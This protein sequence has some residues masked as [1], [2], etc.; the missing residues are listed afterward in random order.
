MPLHP[1]PS[2]AP[3]AWLALLGL[4]PACGA[5]APRAP[6]AGL[7]VVLIVIDTLAAEHVGSY[8]GD[9]R[10]T[11]RLDELASRSVRFRH[12][13]APAPWTQPSV[14]SL[15]TSRMPSAHGVLRLRDS[16]PETATTLAESLRERGFATAAVVSHDL[17][18]ARHG[19]LQG[20]EHRDESAIGG[21]RESTSERATDAALAWLE[22]R[23]QD[24]PF[25]L[26]A[27]YFDPHYPYLDHADFDFTH[28]FE[29]RLTPG[30]GIW[31]LLDQRASLSPHDIAYLVALYREEIAAT[32]RAIGR[33]LDGL[34]ARGLSDKTLVIVTAD[35][36]EEFM[37]HGWIGHT[38]TL[39][40]E[41]LAV[42]LVV[43]LPG[44][45]GARTVDTPVS[46]LDLA[47]T[48]LEA[49]GASPLEGSS[50][51][52]LMP[53]LLGRPATDDA[54]RELNQRRLWAEV[55]FVSGKEEKA[56]LLEKTA[57][58]TALLAHPFKLVHDLLGDRWELY[59]RD[60]D[61]HEL[62]DLAAAQPERLAALRAELASW[63][64]ARTAD[65]DGGPAP[66]VAPSS[67]EIERLRALG[68]IE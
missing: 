4:L 21:P 25:F 27:H 36:G 9:P 23:P 59:D 64:A 34:A 2:R 47:P 51:R 10:T 54:V 60:T 28:G 17:I 16:L 12:A 3:Y 58:K 18:G 19:F 6:A 65:A 22:R 5:P 53:L 48:V 62:H 20:F 8:G 37:R 50:G 14:A 38:R 49:A 15:F 7:N 46:L 56:H 67:E 30:L 52:S 63:E 55:S 41:L 61:P 31:T 68:Y 24:R 39:Y 44:R 29:T 45:F 43:S 11:P 66:T 33:L 40:D 57:F 1:R 32:D 13:F 42:P 35:H 26:F